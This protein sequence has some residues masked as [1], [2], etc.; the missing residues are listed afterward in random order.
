VAVNGVCLTASGL[1]DTGFAADVMHET[2]DRSSPGGPDRRQPGEPGAGHGGGGPTSGGTSYPAISTAPA[3]WAAL[4]RDDNAVWYTVEAALPLLRYVVRRAPSPS[5][6]SSLTVARVEAGPLLRLPHPPPR[7][8]HR[9]GAQAP[10]RR[11][12]SRDGRDR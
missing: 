5:T 4:R 10:R 8:R 3:A 6:A 12:Q 7:R 1:D 9:A 11:G 2:L